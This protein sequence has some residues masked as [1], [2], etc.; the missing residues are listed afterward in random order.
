MGTTL[1]LP[2]TGSTVLKA[3]ETE[4]RRLHAWAAGLVKEVE[5][6]RDDALRRLGPERIGPGQGHRGRRETGTDKVEASRYKAALPER[7]LGEEVCLHHLIHAS[8]GWIW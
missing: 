3:L 2:D 7:G 5:G 1:E 6:R 8:S 4:R